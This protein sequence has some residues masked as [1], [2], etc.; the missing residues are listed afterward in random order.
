MTASLALGFNAR[1]DDLYERE[2]LARPDARFLEFLGEGD[3]EW[4]S[5]LVAA[6]QAPQAVERGTESEL[7]IEL[8]P[9]LESFMGE[10]FGVSKE[11]AALR[12]GRD[13][14]S[15]IYSVKRLF[16]QRRATKKYAADAASLPGLTLQAEIEALIGEPL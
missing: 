13:A 10:L 8:A 6:R 11:L 5:R 16:V 14:L 3:G 7:L 4:K 12:D 9:V 2:G 1:F 15:K